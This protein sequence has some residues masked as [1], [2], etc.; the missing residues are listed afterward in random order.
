VANGSALREVAREQ[1]VRHTATLA[2]AVIN[3]Y[4]DHDLARFEELHGP[5][6]RISFANV[7]GDIS[8]ARG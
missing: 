4:N 7:V 5:A 2:T 3:A 8:R 1:T 6:A